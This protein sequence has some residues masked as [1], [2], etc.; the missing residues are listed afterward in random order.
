M[1]LLSQGSQWQE[2]ELPFDCPGQ[3]QCQAQ[4]SGSTAV[5]KSAGAGTGALL[6]T[7]PGTDQG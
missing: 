6:R 7:S 1:A 3:T 2:Q 4:L 5:E